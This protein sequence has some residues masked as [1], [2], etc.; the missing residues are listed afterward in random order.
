MDTNGC[1]W[2][3]MGMLGCRDTELQQNEEMRD[4]MG[5][6]VMNVT[7]WPGKFPRTSCFFELCSEI[8]KHIQTHDLNHI[9][10]FMGCVCAW[11]MVLGGPGIIL[12]LEGL[13]FTGREELRSSTVVL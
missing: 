6:Q 10:I 7:L 4:K 2:V 12:G 8:L 13:V 5:K 11:G 1:K 3:C 9:S